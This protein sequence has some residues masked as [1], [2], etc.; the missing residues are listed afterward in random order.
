MITLKSIR[1]IVIDWIEDDSDT[2]AIDRTINAQ[3]RFV[4]RSH[5]FEGLTRTADITP[6]AG[7]I[8]TCPAVY[9]TCTG[10]YPMTE[11]G[12]LP[13]FEFYPRTKRTRADEPRTNRYLYYPSES[14]RED[15]A[16][17]I[18]VAGTQ[19]SPTLTYASGTAI[20]DDM[21]GKELKIAG[22][23]TRYLIVA[24]VAGTSLTVFPSLRAESY[25]SHVAT[26]NPSGMRKYILTYPG[27]ALYT[28]S[29]TMDYQIDHPPLVLDD[30][31]LLI[32]MERTIALLTVQQFLQQSKYDVDAQRLENAI[33]EAKLMEY[34]S[35][36]S[37][38][39][40]S[41][42]KDTMFAFRSKRGRNTGR[43]G[44]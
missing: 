43:R 9:G 21:A 16:T 25:A 42:P 18:V 33:F 11:R 6:D 19:G 29:V 3:L 14:S 31:E 26:V 1:D 30:D 27:G 12:E 40:D 15:E 7:G 38:R 24:A 20:T 23:N 8:I 32:P 2:D 35:E 44:R 34:G 39:Q 13:K 5:E 37:N 41:A 36:P 4:S 22:D 10:I 17:G 28:D